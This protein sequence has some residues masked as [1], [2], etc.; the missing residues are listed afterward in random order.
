MRS[1]PAHASQFVLTLKSEEQVTML[2]DRR[3][4]KGMTLIFAQIMDV[5]KLFT[6]CNFCTVLQFT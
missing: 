2:S 1:R 5:C 6:E 4:L 3:I